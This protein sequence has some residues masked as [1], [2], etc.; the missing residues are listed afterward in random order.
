MSAERDRILKMVESGAINAAE[1][2]ELLAA[3]EG[4]SA[5]VPAYIAGPTPNRP[6]EAPFFGGIVLAGFG[7]LGLMRRR[8]GNLFSRLGAW[9]T[10]LAGA[11]A[12]LIGFWSRNAPWLHINVREPGGHNVRLTIP[13]LLPLLRAALE[14]AR[15]FADEAAAEQLDYAA[16]FIEGV[17]RGEQRDPISI[18]IDGGDGA[19]VQI[20]V[21]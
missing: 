3:L 6:W 20:Y 8:R 17:Q 15:G 11:G 1:G 5:A 12:A 9:L 19:Q 10:L 21:A 2:A 4:E 18:D 14:L 16:A 13:L 7:L